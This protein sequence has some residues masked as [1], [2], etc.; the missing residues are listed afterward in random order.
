MSERKTTVWGLILSFKDEVDIPHA[1]KATHNLLSS[2]R[3]KASKNNW[4]YDALAVGSCI[5]PDTKEPVRTHVHLYLEANPGSTVVDWIK[6]YWYQ[7]NGIGK[8]IPLDGN[9]AFL[10][11]LYRQASFKFE[12]WS[13]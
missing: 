8:D 2:L 12:Q 11:Y 9:L 1:Y 3:Y 13:K 5:N 6:H 10:S 4:K 7:R